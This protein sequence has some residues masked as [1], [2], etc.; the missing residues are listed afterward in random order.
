MNSDT[1]SLQT[2]RRIS[3]G[4]S[5]E[6]FEVGKVENYAL[7]VMHITMDQSINFRT[8]RQFISEHEKLN[9]LKHLNI[10]RTYGIFMSDE[11]TPPSI[12]LEL[13]VSD[14]NSAIK[15]NNLKNDQIIIYAYQIAEGMKFVHLKG[16]VHRDLK[17]SNILI[18]KDGTIKI[19]D[20][21]ISKLM[22]AEE[23]STTLGP[24]T[25]KFMAPEILNEEDYNN[26]NGQWKKASNSFIFH[27]FC[28]ELNKPKSRPSFEEILQ[29]ME[30][31]DY[32][33]LELSDS[34]IKSI[35]QFVKQHKQRLPH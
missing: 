24:G 16:F 17:P 1:Q 31:N 28:K 18:A 33:L 15:K 5:G 22:T 25:Q 13:C 4:A 26:S 14:L 35:R 9:M 34:D 32:K 2:I 12:L 20:F 10:I 7:K 30:K 19:S 23:Q 8:Q 3:S 27:C 29:Q 11:T 6:V 21:G